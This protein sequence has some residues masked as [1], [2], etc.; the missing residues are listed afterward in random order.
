MSGEFRKETVSVVVGGERISQEVYVDTQTGLDVDPHSGVFRTRKETTDHLAEVYNVGKDTMRGELERYN[1]WMMGRGGKRGD[2]MMP[3]SGPILKKVSTGGPSAASASSSSGGLSRS[4]G[5]G[6]KGAPLDAASIDAQCEALKATANRLFSEKK[7]H[8]ALLLYGRIEALLG[9]LVLVY[10]L[11]PPSPSA[12]ATKTDAAAITFGESPAEGSGAPFITVTSGLT[13]AAL[14]AMGCPTIEA[15]LLRMSFADLGMAPLDGEG[16][17]SSIR[18]PSLSLMPMTADQYRAA[19]AVAGQRGQSSH[20]ALLPKVNTLARRAYLAVC[21]SNAAEAHLRLG[22]PLE[23]FRCASVATALDDTNLKAAYRAA[24]GALGCGELL[25]P[26]STAERTRR[27][28][29]STPEAIAKAA[30]REVI[31]SAA[32][33]AFGGGP[34]AEVALRHQR[35][36]AAEANQT[37]VVQSPLQWFEAGLAIA[38]EAVAAMGEETPA[39]VVEQ[40]A[41]LEGRLAV[42]AEAAAEADE[43]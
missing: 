42:A 20:R 18:P 21:L 35:K 36:A 28:L 1:E 13:D 17:V 26:L 33:I 34:A 29:E 25:A 11:P 2:P 43:S 27:R 10:P 16:A 9:P 39:A 31:A 19:A 32:R 38:T 40:M 3:Q 37:T 41:D 14:R 24:S 5:G 7:Y 12:A 4:A 6:A 22:R 30:D 23:A 15:V 8:H